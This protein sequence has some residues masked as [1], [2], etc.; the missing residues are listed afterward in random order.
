MAQMDTVHAKIL[1]QINLTELDI[2][3]R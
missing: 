3:A 1:I 2:S